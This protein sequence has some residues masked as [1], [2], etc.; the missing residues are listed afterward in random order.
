[1]PKN[2]GALFSLRLFHAHVSLGVAGR[3]FVTYRQRYAAVYDAGLLQIVLVFTVSCRFDDDS[4]GAGQ[5][6]NEAIVVQIVNRFAIVVLRRPR[7]T[8]IG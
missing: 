2:S 6:G 7:S 8:G 4:H 3:S 1:M 5:H